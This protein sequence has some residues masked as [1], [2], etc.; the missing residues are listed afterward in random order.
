MYCKCGEIAWLK[1]LDGPDFLGSMCCFRIYFYKNVIAHYAINIGSCNRLF[2]GLLPHLDLFTLF[3]EGLW[4]FWEAKGLKLSNI[5]ISQLK[6]LLF[7]TQY[8][9]LGF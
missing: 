3:L 6:Y 5:W 1:G 8:V 2:G 9:G 7:N 4:P